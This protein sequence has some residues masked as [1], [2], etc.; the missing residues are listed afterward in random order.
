MIYQ[1]IIF[2]NNPNFWDFILSNNYINIFLLLGVLFLLIATLKKT[3]FWERDEKVNSRTP[4]SIGLI[5]IAI[6]LFLLFQPTICTLPNKKLVFDCSKV[7]E[8]SILSCKTN[9]EHR[10]KQIVKIFSDTN[11]T[12]KQ[13]DGQ[14]SKKQI[15][16]N[17]HSVIRYFKKEDLEKAKLIIHH[18]EKNTDIKL[19]LADFSFYN[20]A[21]NNENLKGKFEIWLNND[22]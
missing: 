13:L 5:L 18:I 21:K 20:F 22:K 10:I 3:N 1:K 8:I 12:I 4:L 2:L 19:S 9:D 16:L 14:L 7:N 6:S 17:P 11:C 15:E